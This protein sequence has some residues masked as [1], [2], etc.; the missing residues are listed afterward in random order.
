MMNNFEYTCIDC[1]THLY[2][3]FKVI[4]LSPQTTSQLRCLSLEIIKMMTPYFKQSSLINIGWDRRWWRENERF[5]YGMIA[6][7]V[8][9]YAD[10]YLLLRR[11]RQTEIERERESYPEESRADETHGWHSFI[12]WRNPFVSSSRA[13]QPVF[14]VKNNNMFVCWRWV[15]S[16]NDPDP[17][18]VY[19]LQVNLFSP[20]SLDWILS[21]CNKCTVKGVFSLQKFGSFTF[22]GNLFFSLSPFVEGTPLYQR[23]YVLFAARHVRGFHATCSTDM[24]CFLVKQRLIIRRSENNIYTVSWWVWCNRR[25]RWWLQWQPFTSLKSSLPAASL[26]VSGMDFMTFSANK[27]I[28]GFNYANI[29][30]QM[31]QHL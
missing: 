9:L 28:S 29:G 19:P 20:S 27:N 26:S 25:W 10:P 18:A 17:D 24:S 13:S 12:A 11:G 31:W 30:T 6:Q 7:V 22:L 2:Q 15:I 4:T 21:W 5:F 3:S 16:H 23:I 8:A 14:A 1:H